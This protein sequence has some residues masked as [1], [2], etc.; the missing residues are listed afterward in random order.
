MNY[1]FLKL[2]GIALTVGGSAFLLKE[3][4]Q[5]RRNRNHQIRILSAPPSTVRL[6]PHGDN[7][8][9]AEVSQEVFKT[10]STDPNYAGDYNGYLT[11]AKSWVPGLK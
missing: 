1:R 7:T 4:L 11:K 5:Q 9:R 8:D 2:I 6:G 10:S 3:A